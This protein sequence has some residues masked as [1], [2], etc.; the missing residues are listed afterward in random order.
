MSSVYVKQNKDLSGVK[1][2]SSKKAY[3]HNLKTGERNKLTLIM[4]SLERSI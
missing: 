4:S 2:I 1:V 3:V